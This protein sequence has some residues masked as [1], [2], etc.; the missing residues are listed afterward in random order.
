MVPLHSLWGFGDLTLK[1]PGY[2]GGIEDWASGGGVGGL[3]S[4]PQILAADRVTMAKI[5]RLLGANILYKTV[6]VRFPNFAFIYFTL[7]NLCSCMHK[8]YFGL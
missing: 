4:L 5:C 3:G 7:I 2:F 1:G 6:A 8:S